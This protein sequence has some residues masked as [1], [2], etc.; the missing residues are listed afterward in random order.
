MS[1]T[2]EQLRQDTAQWTRDLIRDLYIIRSRALSRRA[3]DA[4]H[5]QPDAN[6]VDRVQRDARSER[7]GI[8]TTRMERGF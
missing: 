1:T 4:T 8:A 6:V 5:G 7:S 3:L 2:G